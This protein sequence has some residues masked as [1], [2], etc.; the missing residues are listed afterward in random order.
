MCVFY[1][2]A[3]Q[4][5]TTF[6]LSMLLLLPRQ[7][8]KH[9]KISLEDTTEVTQVGHS[10]VSDSLN[11]RPSLNNDTQWTTVRYYLTSS[12]FNKENLKKKKKK[13]KSFGK[14]KKK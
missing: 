3:L 8:R 2:D 5:V 4:T 7:R 14:E 11:F 1:C 13:K 9:Q 6:F 12:E 10:D